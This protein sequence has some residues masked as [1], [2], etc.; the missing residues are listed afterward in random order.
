[1]VHP[2]RFFG[3]PAIGAGTDEVAKSTQN[4]IVIGCEDRQRREVDFAMV[5]YSARIP[6]QRVSGWKKD[7]T[8]P[9]W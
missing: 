7:T 4:P 9:W 8:K 6:D 5:D 1:L 2:V 3:R